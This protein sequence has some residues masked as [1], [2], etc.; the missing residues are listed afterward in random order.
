MIETQVTG[1]LTAANTV[2]PL[3]VIA[4]AISD[5]MSRQIS[6]KDFIIR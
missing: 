5:V 4:D 2:V 1:R 6:T 3:D